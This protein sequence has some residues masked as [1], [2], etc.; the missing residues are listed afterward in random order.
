MGHIENQELIMGIYRTLQHFSKKSRARSVIHLAH[1]IG[2]H[3][4]PWHPAIGKSSASRALA[5]AQKLET[6]LQEHSDQGN[7][8]ID[9]NSDSILAP[10]LTTIMRLHNW[11]KDLSGLDSLSREL[12]KLITSHCIWGNRCKR[13]LSVRHGLLS[14]GG[15]FY[16]TR[17]KSASSRGA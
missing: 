4:Q 9:N 3:Q 14:G 5:G 6:S 13:G 11:L 8:S 12:H 1:C 2:M 17:N 7:C 15:L 10:L 16:V